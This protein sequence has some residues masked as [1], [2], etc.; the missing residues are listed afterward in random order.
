VTVE[1]L[2]ERV[3]RLKVYRARGR[4]ALYQP[5][6]LL[7][8][9]GRASHGQPR[10]VPWPETEQELR[11]LIERHGVHG[12]RGRPDYPV[13]ALHRAGL[14]EIRGHNGA[15]PAAHGDAHLRRWFTDNQPTSGLSEDVYPIMRDSRQGRS[16]VV[17][18]IN[19]TYLDDMNYEQLLRD[20]QLAD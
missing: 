10:L 5:I 19:E 18:A 16:A 14:W 2:V 11:R 4:P 3:Q 1:E 17:D 13:A 7:W 12:E 6:T 9:I 8:A 20:V 15:V